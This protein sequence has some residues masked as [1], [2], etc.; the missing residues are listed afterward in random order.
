M[1]DRIIIF[2][3]LV[4]TQTNPSI[5]KRAKPNLLSNILQGVLDLPLTRNQQ[6]F[7]IPQQ[8]NEPNEKQNSN[9]FDPQALNRY[10]D[11]LLRYILQEE[12]SQSSGLS[13]LDIYNTIN[14]NHKK[15]KVEN[16]TSTTTEDDSINAIKEFSDVSWP[17]PDPDTLS[18][19][20][21]ITYF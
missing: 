3:F 8:N 2:L 15:R 19:Q 4:I 16:F 1:K 7:Q 14:K 12:N 10:K 18:N 6:Q 20:I 21:N 17:D 5:G 11:E 13:E 9:T